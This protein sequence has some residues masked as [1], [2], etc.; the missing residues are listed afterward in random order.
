KFHDNNCIQTQVLYGTVVEVIERQGDW[1]QIVIPDQPSRKDQRGY[2]GWMPA[3]QLH[4]LP[5]SY[6]ADDQQPIAMVMKPTAKLYDQEGKERMELSFV[7]RLPA[8]DESSQW[9]KV[10]LPN[11]ES[12]MLRRDD[13]QVFVGSPQPPQD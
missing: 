6:R 4:P 7:T 9:V 2:P 11:G 12:G 13:T 10:L 1:C 3:R 8:L 5:P